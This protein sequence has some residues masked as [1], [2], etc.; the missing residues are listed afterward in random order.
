M[1]E[2]TNPRAGGAGS[3]TTFGLTGDAARIAAINIEMFDLKKIIDGNKPGSKKYKTAL[4]QY[5]A[6]KKEKS[7][8]ESK[9]KAEVAGRKKAAADKA[10][11]KALEDLERAEALGDEK[12]AQNARD[13]ITKAEQAANESGTKTY[14]QQREEGIAAS[15]AKGYTGTGTK[16]K[17][18]ELG[19]EPFSGTYKGKKYENGILVTAPTTTGS[20]KGTGTGDGDGK[21]K[22]DKTQWVSYLRLVF[23][24]VDDK[25]EKAQIDALFDK[26]IKENWGE[27]KFMENLK[28][29]KWWQGN[30]ASFRQFFLESR[31][32]RNAGTFAE[33]VKNNIDSITA[34]I[35]ALGIAPRSVDPV[36]GKVIDNS[37]FMESVALEAIKN[38]W[39]DDQLE[40]YLSTKSNIIF[41]G[42]GTIGSYLD[43]VKS[44]AYL[45]GVKLD[46]NM[47]KDINTS[48]LDPLDGRDYN[49]WINSMKQM[50]IDA[51]ENKPFAESLKAGRSLYEVTASY[52]NQM[53]S[54]LEVDSTA[55]TWDD[56]M[57][58][59][60]DGTTNNARTFADFT[61]ALKQDP[62]WQY[63]R[64]AKETYSGMALDLA[65]MFGFAG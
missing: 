2:I 46:A 53:A 8:L 49:Y 18:L 41:T 35:E 28:G 11:A 22:D 23:K 61:K 50:A 55:I 24:T 3:S 26:A 62:L 57:G 59:I 64:N 27:D 43:R 48:L 44:T 13:R 9:G 16:D 37:P 38:N 32:P 29:T 65:K 45:Y 36:T 60:V 20:G 25:E 58:K 10:K 39:T 56:L 7:D 42:G 1:A 5:N 63:T 15:G 12:A 33:K 31:D 14:N 17:P 54:L 21:V 19:G 30:F 40:N 4:S 6:L 34:K 47:E 52:R 51:P